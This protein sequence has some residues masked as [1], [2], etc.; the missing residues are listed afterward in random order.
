[1]QPQLASEIRKFESW[2]HKVYLISDKLVFGDVVVALYVL[3]AA[4]A[5]CL[6]SADLRSARWICSFLCMFKRFT[7]LS[8]LWHMPCL[9]VRANRLKTNK[10]RGPKTSIASNKESESPF[11]MARKGNSGIGGPVSPLQIS[12]AKK[13]VKN[14]IYESKSQELNIPTAKPRLDSQNCVPKF[15]SC[16]P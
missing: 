7:E 13:K 15:S 3:I 1:M 9:C 10:R 4:L 8:F 6:C 2:K 11:T 12:K 14:R 5:R 16:A